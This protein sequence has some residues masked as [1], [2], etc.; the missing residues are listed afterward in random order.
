LKQFFIANYKTSPSLEGA[1]NL[2]AQSA[3]KL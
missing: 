3:G 2:L 1:N